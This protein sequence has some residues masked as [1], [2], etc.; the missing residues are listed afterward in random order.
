MMAR[1]VSRSARASFSRLSTTTPTPLPKTVPAASASNDSAPAIGRDDAAL[2]VQIPALLGDIDRHASREGDVALVVEEALARDV[3]GHQRRR[4]E[5]LDR[6]ARALEIELVGS[7]R[8]RRARAVVDCRLDV[9]ERLH[10]RAVPVQLMRQVR[11]RRRAGDQPDGSREPLRIVPGLLER[12]PRAFEEQAL[13]RIENFCLARCQPEEG[14]VEQV[15][16]CD[17]SPGPDVVRIAGELGILACS[18][19]LVAAEGRDRFDAVAEVLPERGHV[20]RARESP[21]HR[22]HGDFRSVELVRVQVLHSRLV[23]SPLR[24]VQLT[25][26]APD[27]SAGG[28]ARGSAPFAAGRDR[29]C[30]RM[31]AV[32]QIH[33]R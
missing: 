22:A 12:L 31:I 4:A 10:R 21:G 13:L 28:R 33:G 25:A 29:G 30:C 9:S 7:Q 32:R 15:G 2:L 19:H 23:S 14:G 6:T 26:P 16:A 17:H 24:N 1:T 20:A 8:C 5:R 18:Q 3:D 27:R 11:A